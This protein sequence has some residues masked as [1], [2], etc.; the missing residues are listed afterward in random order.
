MKY[1]KLNSILSI[2]NPASFISVEE[3]EINVSDDIS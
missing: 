2:R 3:E 1:N